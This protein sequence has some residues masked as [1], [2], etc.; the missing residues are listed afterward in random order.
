M[1]IELTLLKGEII[2]NEAGINLYNCRLLLIKE[3]DFW[4]SISRRKFNTCSPKT[5]CKYQIIQINMWG[6]K[7]YYFKTLKEACELS[8]NKIKNEKIPN[9]EAALMRLTAM[10]DCE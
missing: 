6:S 10:L 5:G 7:F 8:I 3:N 9:K 4:F 1:E 2:T